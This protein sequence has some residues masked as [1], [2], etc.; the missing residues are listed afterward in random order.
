MATVLDPPCFWISKV[1]ESTPFRRTRVRAST[2][3]SSTR[4]TSE[5]WTWEP[6]ASDATTMDRMS[7]RV[8][9]RPSVF[10][11]SS[12]PPLVTRPPGRSKPSEPICCATWEMDRPSES[13]R[14]RSTNTWISRCLPPMTFTAPTPST[15]STLGLMTS[16]TMRRVSAT[17]RL[18]LTE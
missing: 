3:P 4:A 2:K 16:S 9:K 15:A 13:S 10:T 12:E 6:L 7:S 11:F 17:G 18:E 14:E 5:R 8:R 1:T